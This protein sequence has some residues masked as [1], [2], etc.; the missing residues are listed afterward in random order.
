MLLTCGPIDSQKILDLSSGR[1]NEITCSYQGVARPLQ[2]VSA[3]VCTRGVHG[4]I[5]HISTE[6]RIPWLPIFSGWLAETMIACK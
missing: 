2:S 6:L 1:A 5:H 4:R 3:E